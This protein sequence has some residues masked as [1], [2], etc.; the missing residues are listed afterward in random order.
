[1]F[2]CFWHLQHREWAQVAVGLLTRGR[3]FWFM[4]AGVKISV[5]QVLTVLCLAGGGRGRAREMERWR[6]K[7]KRLGR[8]LGRVR[9][10]SLRLLGLWCARTCFIEYLL[11]AGTPML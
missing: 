9:F 2:V 6:R 5:P 11:C 7:E 4:G 8:G 10:S 1:M 3:T